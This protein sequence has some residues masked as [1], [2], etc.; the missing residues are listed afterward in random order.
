[1]NSTD[2]LI[3]LSFFIISFLLGMISFA[4]KSR[5][6]E[7]NLRLLDTLED[8]PPSFCQNLIELTFAKTGTLLSAQMDLTDTLYASCDMVA[9]I[10]GC[11]ASLLT[12]SDDHSDELIVASS[13]GLNNPP[14]TLPR[15][16][17]LSAKVLADGQALAVN[18]PQ[19]QQDL[20]CPLLVFSHVTSLLCAP[21][22]YGDTTLGTIEVY[23]VSGKVFTDRDI[24][25]LSA[26]ARNAAVA[27]TNARQYEAAKRSLEEERNLSSLT[28]IA[29]TTIDPTVI[30][31]ES[32]NCTKHALNVLW[33]I[34]ALMNHTDIYEW[35]YPS[36]DS[37]EL[38]LV[39]DPSLRDILSRDEPTLLT[40]PPSI[41]T[42]VLL[43]A[44]QYL[45]LPL[46]CNQESIGFLLCGLDNRPFTQFSFA[47][48][49][50]RQISFNL[51]KLQLY[52][53]VKSMALSDG[54]TGLANRR[55]F[56]MLL[57]T[58]LRRSASLQRHLSLIMLDLDKF[59]QY[60]DTYGHP[61]G[62]K[63]LAQVGQIIHH[64][65][66]SI[67]LAARYGGEE[68]SI[69]LPECNSTDAYTIAEKL[70]TTI[71]QSHFP[72]SLG[73]FTASITASIGIATYDPTATLHAPD[74]EK[75]ISLADKA[76]Y[77]AKEEGRNRIFANTNFS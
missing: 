58:E 54:L 4:Y 9:D 15:A 8:Q 65:I 25:L 33:C 71:E 73:T 64:N 29:T 22:L 16:N 77:Q 45:L 37:V 2:C 36:A 17:S 10:L 75:I 40:T 38:H 63:L 27:I 49:I 53:Q 12:L 42:N 62:D 32:A 44:T 56:D 19:T 1:M 76:L 20:F 46:L 3:W 13:Y 67:D 7:R 6:I 61:I 52:N 74:S 50:A 5:R 24:L 60:N 69:I 72:D 43:P 70:R 68:F 23:S 18:A 57:K 55:N 34:P 41:P 31:T 51:Q 26:L 59:K 66:R 14:A 47:K 39:N 21:L 30:L 28:R 11:S 35:L 48:Q